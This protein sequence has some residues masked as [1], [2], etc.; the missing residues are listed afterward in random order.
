MTDQDGRQGHED[1]QCEK[2]RW[3]AENASLGA[4]QVAKEWNKL[5]K[6]L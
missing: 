3:C 2:S 6:I 1:F 5:V 4:K